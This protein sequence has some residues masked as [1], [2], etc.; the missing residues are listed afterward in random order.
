MRWLSFKHCALGSKGVRVLGPHISKMSFQVL[1]FERCGL[2]D[3]CCPAISSILKVH[4]YHYYNIEVIFTK[5]SLMITVVELTYVLTLF[6][7]V[8]TPHTLF[9]ENCEILNILTNIKSVQK[10]LLEPLYNYFVPLR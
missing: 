5:L 6:S 7:S 10:F 9:G 2:C 3:D 4:H 1:V 8:C